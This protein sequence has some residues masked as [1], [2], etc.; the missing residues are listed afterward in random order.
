MFALTLKEI[1]ALFNNIRKILAMLDKIYHAVEGNKPEEWPSE[2]VERTRP[3]RYDASD[4]ARKNLQGNRGDIQARKNSRHDRR[5]R[6]LH[7]HGI[8]KK[9]L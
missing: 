1:N 9:R 3:D 6:I 8:Q 7:Q 2:N 4:D 5:R